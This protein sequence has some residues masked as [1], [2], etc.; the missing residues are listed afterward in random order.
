M[1]YLVCLLSCSL[2]AVLPPYAQ[3]AK[4]NIYVTSAV[5]Y[6]NRIVGSG[7]TVSI[8]SIDVNYWGDVNP[9]SD[10]SK[11]PSISY[12]ATAVSS[13]AN[14]FSAVSC[15]VG[16]DGGD[17]PVGIQRKEGIAKDVG[18]P[19]DCYEIYGRGESLIEFK[20]YKQGYDTLK[21]MVE[22]CA[23]NNFWPYAQSAF[24]VM[25]A[26]LKY[27]DDP[28]IIR[29]HVDWMKSVL[30]LNTINPQ[31]YCQAAEWIMRCVSGDSVNAPIDFNDMLAVTK[32]ILESGKCDFERADWERWYED[33][34]RQQRE[35]WVLSWGVDTALHPLD[36][37]IPTLEDLDLEIL[38]GQQGSVAS[39]ETSA[40]SLLDVR[41]VTN[42]FSTATEI[43]YTLGNSAQVELSLFNALGQV[44]WSQPFGKVEYAATHKASIGG[45][46]L[47]SGSYFL[48]VAT[49]TGD[50]RTVKL[51]K[52]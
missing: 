7:G 43:E 37:T 9:V 29:K 27:S 15:G 35:A 47:Q 13:A 48:R 4:N 17:E 41:A 2:S 32:Y 6:K 10:A 21:Y 40:P 1:K 45:E 12:S 3:Q 11:F 51:I 14:T 42:P 25:P 20:E 19:A 18:S 39:G 26:G 52:H 16:F 8:G 34:R 44:V 33:F 38:R 36:T 24:A 49:L 30:Y 31:Y 5:S 23:P 46:D 50:V 28:Y 22:H